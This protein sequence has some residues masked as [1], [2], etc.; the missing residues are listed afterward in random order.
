[1][2]KPPTTSMISP[3]PFAGGGWI[4]PFFIG[5]RL[6]LI[7]A[8]GRA[9]SNDTMICEACEFK[10]HFL[11][12]SPAVSLDSEYRRRP[13]RLFRHIRKHHPLPFHRFCSNG[14]PG[15]LSPTP[16]T[17]TRKKALEGVTKE[18]ITFGYHPE[19]HWQARN[20]VME[21]GSFA[22]YDLY[23]NGSFAA[24]IS[25]GVPGAHNVLNSTAAAAAAHCGANY[26][27]IAEGAVQLS[28]GWTPL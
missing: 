15:P 12:L 19:C 5:G 23:H 11:E 26:A 4:L 2:E 25:L 22:S 24:A 28:R 10:D 27:Q 6:P 8:N 3:N 17:P 21:R 16:R 1:M 14:L 20:V 13:S 18:I 9:G 7:E